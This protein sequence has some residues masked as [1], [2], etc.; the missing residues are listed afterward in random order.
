MFKIKSDTSQ[1]KLAGNELNDIT[2]KD[3]TDVQWHSHWQTGELTTDPQGYVCW[4]QK[5]RQFYSA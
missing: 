4:F 2:T 3:K 1:Q 5:Q